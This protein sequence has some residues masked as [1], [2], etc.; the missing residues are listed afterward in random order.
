MPGAPTQERI[1]V[2]PVENNK[3]LYLIEFSG[4]NIFHLD[5]SKHAP[6]FQPHFPEFHGI[7][8]RETE[9]KHE[10][11]LLVLNPWWG[12]VPAGTKPKQTETFMTAF[13]RRKVAGQLL[14]PLSPLG[15]LCA[16]LMRLCVLSID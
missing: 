2:G 10:V 4:V 8:M 12:L 1:L 13:P 5:F 3:T 6:L 16:S 7:T 14:R 15:S 11:S 9:H